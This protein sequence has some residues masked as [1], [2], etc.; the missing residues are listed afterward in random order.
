MGLASASNAIVEAALQINTDYV[1]WTEMD[2]I[3]PPHTI[4]TLLK[5][6]QQYDLPVLSGVYFLRGNAQPCL[7]RKS[8]HKGASRYAHTIMTVFPKDSLFPVDVPGVGCVLFKT[9]VFKKIS[10]PWWDDQEGTCGQDMY[11]YTKCREAGIKVYADSTVICGQIDDDEPKMW[12]EAEYL[13]WR[14]THAGT[15]YVLTA[16][17]PSVIHV[18]K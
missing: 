6:A 10:K 15:G 9:E 5:H 11:F 8:P 1:F 17:H 13:K 18:E 14:E 7:Y 16:D 12:D 3:L 4:A 2:M